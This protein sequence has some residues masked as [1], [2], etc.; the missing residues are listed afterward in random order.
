MVGIDLALQ[1]ADLAAHHA[2]DFR[3]QILATIILASAQH[4]RTEQLP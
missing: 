1:A 4:D 2:A 3:N